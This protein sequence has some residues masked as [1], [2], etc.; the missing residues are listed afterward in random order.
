MNITRFLAVG[1]VVVLTWACGSKDDNKASRDSSFDAGTFP[2][3]LLQEFSTW[4]PTLEGD[5]TFKSTGHG[6]ITVRSYLNEVAKNHVAAASDPYPMAIGSTLA[7]AVVSSADAVVGT[8][9]TIYFMKKEAAGFDTENGDWSYAVAKRV[10]GV[11]G[12]DTSV[13]PKQ[14]L[15]V[16]CHTKFSEYDYV[17]TIE[18]YKRQT[19]SL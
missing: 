9:S 11:L 17:Q 7:K 10:N 15:C 14:E 1:S 6:G 18:F 5:Q 16:S 13:G 4:T 2:S 19:T 8:A 3:A 12:Y